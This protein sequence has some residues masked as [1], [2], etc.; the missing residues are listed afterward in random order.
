MHLF[1]N[2]I[3]FS[4]LRK[5]EGEDHQ[6]IEVK[7][8]IS[9]QFRLRKQLKITLPNKIIIG[10]FIVVVEPTKT[11]LIDKRTELINRLLKMYSIRMRQKTDEVSK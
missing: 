3:N 2:R 6:S 4:S 1:V 9:K 8:E 11:F 10:P 7:E 5:F